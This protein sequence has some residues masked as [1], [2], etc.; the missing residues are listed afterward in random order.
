MDDQDRARRYA[1]INQ[2]ARRAFLEGAAEEWQRANGRRPT[3]EELGQVL[4]RYPG[5]PML[6]Q[7]RTMISEDADR[8]RPSGRNPALQPE[9]T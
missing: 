4:A 7:S 2:K 1:E 3:E 9:V 8:T 5:D 6:R